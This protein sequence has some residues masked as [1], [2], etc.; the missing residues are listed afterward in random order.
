MQLE[1]FNPAWRQLK[2]LNAMQHVGANEIL[3]II[4]DA[5]NTDS[6]KFPRVL[7]TLVM[8]VVVTVFCQGG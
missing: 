2:L 8:F 7:F 3:A 5:E 4:E 1:N 6:P